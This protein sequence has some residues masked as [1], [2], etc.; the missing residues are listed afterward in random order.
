[1]GT[2]VVELTQ[3]MRQHKKLWLIPILVTTVLVGGLIALTQSS[4]IAPFV[5]TLF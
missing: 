2:F 3:F 4:S 1:M 5:Y